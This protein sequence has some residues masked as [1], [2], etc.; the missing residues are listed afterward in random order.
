MRGMTYSDRPASAL[1]CGLRRLGAMVRI[2][3]TD[4]R[5]HHDLERLAQLSPHLLEDL[6]FRRDAAT[7]TP[8][9][10]VWRRGAHRVSVSTAQDGAVAWSE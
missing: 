7:S 8:Q 5:L 1:T 2:H 10:A 9:V 3:R 6:G 4:E